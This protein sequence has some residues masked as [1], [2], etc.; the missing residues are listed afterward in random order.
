MNRRLF[1]QASFQC[2]VAENGG[3]AVRYLAYYAL[4]FTYDLTPWL[5]IKELYVIDN[6]QCRRKGIG[7]TLMERLTSEA[8]KQGSG[9]IKWKV[10]ST[11]LNAKTFY[12]QL[13]ASSE[14][15]W[16]IW[17]LSKKTIFDLSHQ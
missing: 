7:K 6:R 14:L 9:K 11:N 1:K 12:L 17:S 4:P 10:L 13:G 16:Q 8:H 15:E 3:T 5:W 2:L